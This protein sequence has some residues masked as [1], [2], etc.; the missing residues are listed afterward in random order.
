MRPWMRR[1]AV[2][3]DHMVLG[4][5]TRVPGID[6]AQGRRVG[7]VRDTACDRGRRRG[8]RASGLVS[9]EDRARHEQHREN[10]PSDRTAAAEHARERAQRMDALLAQPDER[11]R[12]NETSQQHTADYL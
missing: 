2:V 10:A 5:Q 4:G 8:C 6:H 7:R 9:A 11:Q 1:T 12:K 3:R